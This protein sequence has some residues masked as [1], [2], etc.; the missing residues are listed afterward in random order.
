MFG[1]NNNSGGGGLFGGGNN[2]TGGG[3]LFGG[4]GNNNG[5]GL[6]GNNGG[7]NVVGGDT[8]IGS[9]EDSGAGSGAQNGPPSEDHK[10]DI[11][12]TGAEM[13]PTDT[14][15]CIKWIKDASQQI[16]ATGDWSGDLKIYQ[17]VANGG[18]CN[19]NLL[20][21]VNIGAPIFKI[22]WSD[23][24]TMI[25]IALA[26]GKVRAMLVQSGE[27]GDLAEHPSLTCMQIVNFQGQL[28]IVTVGTDQNMMFWKP[29]TPQPL[30][31][32]KLQKIPF[33]TDFSFPY[34]VIGCS[35]NTIAVINLEMF[36]KNQQVH[37]TKCNLESPIMSI[38]I[39]PQSLRIALGSV[40]GRIC[41]TDMEFGHN[42]S[43]FKLK[44]F[45]LFRAHRVEIK[46]QPQ[47]SFLYQV[48]CLGFHAKFPN[49]LYSCGSNSVT[50]YWDCIKKNKSAEFSFA[51]MP[52]SAADYSPCGKMF[53][54]ALGYDWSQG[55]WALPKVNYR[56]LVCVH[57]VQNGEVR[58]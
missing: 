9:N 26:S 32:I 45:I 46:N 37:Y 28:V 58:I 56:P 49:F 7:G 1:N 19:L 3:G 17:V 22:D 20:K 33:C 35:D 14:V 34:L 48:N 42:N 6:F 15:Q 8:N 29:G 18:G 30:A 43:S 50:Y 16:F 4:G 31:T 47:N 36:A 53:A 38:A 27:V 21:T 51:D 12:V 13:L 39:R 44:D 11:N 52:I 41:V 10:K 5:G 25:F 54:Y 55:V 23:D 40:D 2:N 57:L 24:N